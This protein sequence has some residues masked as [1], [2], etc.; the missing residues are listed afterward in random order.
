[1]AS[2]FIG[3]A[4]ELR[5][6]TAMLTTP[7]EARVPRSLFIWGV[8]GVGKTWLLRRLVEQAQ[9]VKRPTAVADL[10]YV[11]YPQQALLHLAE[12]LRPYGFAFAAFRATLAVFNLRIGNYAVSVDPQRQRREDL[13]AAASL[14][15]S[16][17]GLIPGVGE[18]VSGFRV[19]SGALLLGK[20]ATSRLAIVRKRL[21]RAGLD[22]VELFKLEA[23]DLAQELVR[24][25]AR[26]IGRHANRRGT[27]V[28]YFDRHEALWR[29]GSAGAQSEDWWLR[30]LHEELGPS[31]LIVVTGRERP[32]S[33][34]EGMVERRLKGLTAAEAAIVLRDASPNVS[35]RVIDSILR[36]TAENRGSHASHHTLL[37]GLC[38]DIL[39]RARTARRPLPPTYFDSVPAGQR[40]ADALT[41]RFLSSVRN[42]ALV[43]WLRE[44]SLSPRFD[45]EYAL[46]LDKHRRY[47]V[48]RAGWQE[49]TSLS[50]VTMNGVGAFEIHPVFR[51][52]L[53]KS[54]DKR[55]SQAVH[56]WSHRFFTT[57][58]RRDGWDA[59]GLA[60]FHQRS[61][62][63]A[64]AAELMRNEIR[65]AA[66][67]SDMARLRVV[68]SW[69][70][71]V[72]LPRQPVDRADAYDLVLVASA[73]VALAS[74]D[75]NSPTEKAVAHCRA[76]LRI[77]KADVGSEEWARAHRVLGDAL[78][79]S[80]TR[81]R[82]RNLRAALRSYRLAS[83]VF[84]QTDPAAFATT[85]NNMGIAYSNPYLWSTDKLESLRRAAIAFETARNAVTATTEPVIW[86]KASMN[87]AG[88]IS[89]LGPVDQVRPLMQRYF[90]DAGSIL[91]R[92]THPFSWALIEFNL[93]VLAWD[94][95]SQESDPR[96]A[97][98]R[99]DAAMQVLT[100]SAYPGQWAL[101]QRSLGLV[102]RKWALRVTGSEA[103]SLL[104]RAVAAFRAALR[105]QTETGLPVPW[106]ETQHELGVAL[107]SY[108]TP[109]SP[110]IMQLAIECLEAALRVRTKEGTPV[111]WAL[112]NLELG[113]AYA[114]TGLKADI[115]KAL[116]YYTQADSV[117]AGRFSESLE[118]AE[119]VG[120]LSEATK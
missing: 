59:L 25:F 36:L 77:L 55:A 64:Q 106:A 91:T 31:A 23:G 83:P 66:D 99:L 108:E 43:G 6:L 75:R 51:A 11:G 27:P 88:V 80:M 69:W 105:V 9:S 5:L 120:A 41:R 56:E 44:L 17:V 70:N 32:R 114:R 45:E 54:V 104:D 28:L 93:G 113:D 29:D 84:E 47:Y 117:L 49:L 13:A 19:L 57:G 18:V 74:M 60:W 63:R 103:S 21:E 111:A 90:R 92:T 40:A 67:K 116:R 62:D 89:E 119:K 46:A 110:G 96:A 78:T 24:A 98:R 107:M 35:S 101:A 48:G 58:S 22:S 97:V 16:T 68:R 30:L 4:K 85:Q 61:L 102:Y 100:E 39:A 38:A 81:R 26:D 76:A 52:V 94:P 20:R 82:T 86:A 118:I 8:A 87:L 10:F 42:E 50:F 7:D 72:E 37:I 15:L 73:L 115:P 71:D 95:T 109:G 1:M 34:L 65:R 33:K 112:T 3:R 79:L 2:H 12:Q 14:S 53:R